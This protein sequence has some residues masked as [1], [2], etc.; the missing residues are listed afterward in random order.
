ML[1]ICKTKVDYVTQSGVFLAKHWFDLH[2]QVQLNLKERGVKL[3]INGGGMTDSSCN[4]EKKER[5]ETF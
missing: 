3:I 5:Q 2:G 1:S 4:E